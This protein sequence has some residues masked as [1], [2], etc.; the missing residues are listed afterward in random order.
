MGKA[1]TAITTRVAPRSTTTTNTTTTAR[2][3]RSTTATAVAPPPTATV[4]LAY[5]TTAVTT[6]LSADGATPPVK[7]KSPL[8]MACIYVHSGVSCRL[9]SNRRSPNGAAACRTDRC[10]ASAS[11]S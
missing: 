7:A 10:R 2:D 4:T 3:A 11:P 8:P 5:T 9:P 1:W 6:K